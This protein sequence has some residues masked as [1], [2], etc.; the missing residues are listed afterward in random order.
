MTRV[1]VLI[2]G[3]GRG[4]AEQLAVGTLRHLDPA[5][6]E[7]EVAYLLPGKD[8]L[9]DEVRAMGIKVHCLGSGAD[10]P[11]RLRTLARHRGI[12]VVHA[13]SPVAASAARVLLKGPHLYTEHNTWP[14]YR[15]PTRLANLLTYPR[16]AHVLAVSNS[17]ETSTLSSMPNNLAK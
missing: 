13:H 16:N 3:L 5:R 10:W 11:M 14:R 9:A 7:C 12:D 1:L 2:K 17:G 4:G 15:R 6:M 8:A